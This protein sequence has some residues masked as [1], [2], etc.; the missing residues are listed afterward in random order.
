MYEGGGEALAVSVADATVV[1]GWLLLVALFIL[2]Q[3]VLFAL[4]AHRALRCSP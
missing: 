3:S 4:V 2:G 1:A